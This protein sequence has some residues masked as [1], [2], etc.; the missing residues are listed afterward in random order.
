MSGLKSVTDPIVSSELCR[1]GLRTK[2]LQ[3]KS[4]RRYVLAMGRRTGCEH[5]L[6]YCGDS[7]KELVR[8]SD[9]EVDRVGLPRRHL[10]K[11]KS[12]GSRLVIH[13]NHPQSMSL[14]PVDI[15]H[16]VARQ[17]LVEIFAH[18]H[19][20]SWYWAA[21]GRK[22]DGLDMV[23]HGETAFVKAAKAMRRQGVVLKDAWM[24]HFFNLALDHSGIITY[25]FGLSP[26]MSADMAQVTSAD[27][28]MLLD[29]VKHAIGKERQ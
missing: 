27:S 7:G 10:A 9:R 6:C 29:C 1:L 21:S 15:Q 16:L 18:G 12:R 13:H 5:L 17:G 4:A 22:R 3:D 11:A 26:A 2:S 24:P 19:D 20:Q 28:T 23:R 8:H 25:K 14:S